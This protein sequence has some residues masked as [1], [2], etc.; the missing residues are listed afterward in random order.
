ML[1][2]RT[3]A[4]FVSLCR[5]R[6]ACINYR[7]PEIDCQMEERRGVV[8]VLSMVTYLLFCQRSSSLGKGQTRPSLFGLTIIDGDW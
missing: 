7:A 3:M 2:N 4:N 5:P 6:L 8:I 1:E